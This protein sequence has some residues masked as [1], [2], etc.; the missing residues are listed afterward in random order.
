M[1]DWYGDME[2]IIDGDV[3]IWANDTC[4]HDW[5]AGAI[6]QS[7]GGDWALESLYIADDG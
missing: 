3:L 7:Y 4:M 6:V 2:V 5:F 1:R